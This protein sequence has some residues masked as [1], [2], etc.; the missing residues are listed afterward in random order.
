[1]MARPD[2]DEAGVRGLEHVADAEVQR[3]GLSLLV[4]GEEIGLLVAVEHVQRALV[5]A[6][7]AH[8]GT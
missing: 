4:S 5:V 3:L 8:I 1:M 7:Q 2:D 6:V